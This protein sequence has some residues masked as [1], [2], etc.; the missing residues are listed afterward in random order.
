MR[1]GPIGPPHVDQFPGVGVFGLELREGR[2]SIDTILVQQVLVLG[3][4]EEGL[5]DFLPETHDGVE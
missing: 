2:V 1:H 3:P 4:R 5:R